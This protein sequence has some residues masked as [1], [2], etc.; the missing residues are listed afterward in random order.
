M[1][2]WRVNQE[3]AHFAATDLQV[4]S[5]T[6]YSLYGVFDGHG[7]RE[8]AHFCKR[9]V[10]SEAEQQLTS[11]LQPPSAEAGKRQEPE[12]QPEQQ[13]ID[14]KVLAEALVRTFHR[15]DELLRMPEHENELLA[16]KRRPSADGGQQA[17]LLTSP[18]A[19]TM[20]QDGSDPAAAAAGR[21]SPPT[22]VSQVQSRLQAAIATDMAQA[23]DRGTLSTQEAMRIAMGMSFL[24]RLDG[25]ASAAPAVPGT[26]ALNVG[27]TAVC[28][29][30]TASHVICANAGDSRAV[31][32]RNGRAVPLS[33][34][35][36]P[37]DKNERKRI[38]AAGGV[39]KE[40]CPAGARGRTQYR[41]NGDLNLSRALGDL[42]HKTRADLR[43]EQQAVA[44]TPDVHIEGREGGD[45]FVVIACDGVWDVR[46]N[47]QVC[48]FVR[49]GIRQ[50]EQLSSI[51][52]RLLDACLSHDPKA[53]QGLGG[54]N[55]TCLVLKF[56]SFDAQAM[57]SPRPVGCLPCRCLR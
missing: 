45:E 40:I 36:K 13:P 38:E 31:L 4:G 2:G 42:R 9:Y 51:I 41:V 18:Q 8:V 23:R 22:Q 24:Q 10:P 44:A 47:T 11:L 56:E 27:C 29:A 19:E 49:Q 55:M 52:E 26:A 15:M 25:S 39:V 50:G 46:T 3:D 6:T 16:F 32:S 21:P 54:D 20:E 53:T 17:D 35:H 12:Q 48:D 30:I 14:A 5:G 43:P 34:D 57:N 28:V 37:N 7:G 1:Q 33:R